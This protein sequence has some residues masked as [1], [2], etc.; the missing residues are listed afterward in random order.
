MKQKLLLVEDEDRLAMVLKTFFE[1][2]N[3]DV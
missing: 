3:F 2:E 1:K